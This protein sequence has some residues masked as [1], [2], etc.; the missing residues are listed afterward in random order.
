MHMTRVFEMYDLAFVDVKN[1]LIVRC[2]DMCLVCKINDY[3]LFCQ[4][5]WLRHKFYAERLQVLKYSRE[6]LKIIV[7]LF[8][9]RFHVVEPT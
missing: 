4:I 5:C 9:E 8:Y 3:C 1:P 6:S 2:L 7:L